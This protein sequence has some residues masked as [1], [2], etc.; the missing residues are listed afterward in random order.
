MLRQAI[1]IGQ[2]LSKK[3]LKYKRVKL[4]SLPERHNISFEQMEIRNTLLDKTIQHH[5]DVSFP[6]SVNLMRSWIMIP[7]FPSTPG[8]R[9]V[10]YKIHLEAQLS[11][12]R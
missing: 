4:Q 6:S 8:A 1:K 9:Q 12:D 3:H 11:K 2:N 5:K 7:S 10:D